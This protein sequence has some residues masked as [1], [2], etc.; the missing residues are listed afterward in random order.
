MRDAIVESERGRTESHPFRIECRPCSSN[1][2]AIVALVTS[3][4]IFLLLTMIFQNLSDWIKS[5]LIVT[6]RLHETFYA[7]GPY[8][9]Q[10][11]DLTPFGPSFGVLVA[12]RGFD[13]MSLPAASTST[14]H[15][16]IPRADTTLQLTRVQYA[17]DRTARRH[18]QVSALAATP[19]VAN[20]N[21]RDVVI[22]II[23]GSLTAT[24]VLLW[25]YISLS[26]D[27]AL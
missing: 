2:P 4:W 23:Q 3:I 13:L 22:H 14:R 15:A 26:E 11:D 20:S 27:L 9:D 17:S 16:Q 21:V 1:L 12:A 25:L 19:L 5:F 6:S 18:F 7:A 10:L 8:T 24:T